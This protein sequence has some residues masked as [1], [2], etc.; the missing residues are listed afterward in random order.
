MINPSTDP[1][2][3]FNIASTIGETHSMIVPEDVQ[4]SRKIDNGP[5]CP[6]T[7]V[8]PKY[9]VVNCHIDHGQDGLLNLVFGQKIILT[10]PPTRKNL[11]ILRNQ[12]PLHILCKDLECG[13]ICLLHEL[14]PNM[15][16]F[17][18]TLHATITLEASVLTGINWFSSHGHRAF[19]ACFAG[20][21]L[22]TRDSAE[23]VT[24]ISNYAH[25]IKLSSRNLESGDIQQILLDWLNIVFPAL[26][27]R[28]N[29][30]V[31][32]HSEIKGLR[33]VLKALIELN[34][35]FVSDLDGMWL[36]EWSVVLGE[37]KTMLGLR[38]R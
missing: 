6:S 33:K 38:Q 11:T 17:G 37:F 30:R 12:K 7:N 28:D 29:V 3:L 8:T 16:I 27:S 36:E 13:I 25:Q 21:E 26:K 34:E 18:G 10:W 32:T 35:N 31:F 9:T 14:S 23:G 22:T 1:A 4:V 20:Y 5:F 19:A 24:A 15:I 2:Y